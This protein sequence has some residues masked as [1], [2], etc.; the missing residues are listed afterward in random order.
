MSEIVSWRDP[1]PGSSDVGVKRFLPLVLAAPCL[2][3]GVPRR[4]IVGGAPVVADALA[5]D[6][7]TILATRHLARGYPA[8]NPDDTVN[9]VVEIPSGTIAKFE[10]DEDTGA[11]RWAKNR[12]D[13]S[14]REI[15]Y[16]PYPVNYGMVPQT[17]ADDGDPLDV[18]VLGRGLER[19]TV[20][21]TRVI[22]VLEM[23]HDGTRD[24]KLIAVPVDLE[25]RNGFSRLHEL[26]ELDDAYPEARTIL[27]L[28]FANYW[29]RGATEVVG[30]G[31]ATEANAILDDA[32]SRAGPATPR[33]STDPR[34]RRGWPFVARDDSPPRPPRH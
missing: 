20:T 31:D 6:A 28:W 30:W 18:L 9:A 3:S 25:L 11:L 23:A 12:E 19:A 26:H 5:V 32:I 2:Y 16:L 14:R 21:S 8:R 13:G 33:D 7:E 34:P 27:V 24:D 15:D 17:L 10:V 1:A 22:G 29:G 4:S